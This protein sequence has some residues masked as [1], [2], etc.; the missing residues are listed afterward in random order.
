MIMVGSRAAVLSGDL[1]DW[2]AGAMKDWDF[3]GSGQD[4]DRMRAYLAARGSFEE[5][6]DRL[7]GTHFLDGKD[8]A[9]S[10]LAWDEVAEAITE[11]P[12]LF[13]AEALG[14]PVTA[15]GPYTQLAL[16]LGYLRC[17]GPHADKNEL[18]V[19]HW[20]STLDPG[21]WTAVHDAILNAMWRRAEEIFQIA[22]S[23]FSGSPEEARLTLFLE[24]R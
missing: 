17:A 3:Y 20:L 23:S 15:I 24:T 4:V 8:L 6:S 18:D 2:R 19:Q 21:G 13:P 16:K 10:F 22:P 11:A 12:D 5:A 14:Q 7:G 1:P 9:I